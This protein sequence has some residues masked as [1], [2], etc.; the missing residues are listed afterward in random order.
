M[1]AESVFLT[2]LDVMM[3]VGTALGVLAVPALLVSRQFR[4]AGK[5]AL[6]VLAAI[7]VNAGAHTSTSLLAR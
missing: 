7:G 2:F 4:V 1:A 3:I 6:G 5:A